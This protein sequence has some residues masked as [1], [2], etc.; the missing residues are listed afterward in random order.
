MRFP[1]EKAKLIH[2]NDPRPKLC[3]INH[4]ASTGYG[5]EYPVIINIVQAANNM[6]TVIGRIFFTMIK[7][8]SLLSSATTPIH[9]SDKLMTYVQKTANHVTHIAPQR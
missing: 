7:I 4:G 2:P 5:I 1:N 3:A 6:T 8:L 9:H